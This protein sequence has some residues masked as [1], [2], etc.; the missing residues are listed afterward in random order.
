MLDVSTWALI[1]SDVSD[2]GEENYKNDEIDE[3][4]IA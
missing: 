4:R 2:V 3:F 1:N